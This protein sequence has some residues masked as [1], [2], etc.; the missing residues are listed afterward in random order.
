MYNQNLASSAPILPMNNTSVAGM[1]ENLIQSG[2]F[3]NV[4]IIQDNSSNTQNNQGGGAVIGSGASTED[5]FYKQ[6][7]L[8]GGAS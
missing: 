6:G 1:L 2:D 5:L 3:G 4:T 8:V 7:Y